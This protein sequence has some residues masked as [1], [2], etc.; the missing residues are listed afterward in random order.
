MTPAIT[1]QM[2]QALDAEHG[3]PVK[4][5]DEKTSQVYYVISAVYFLPSTLYFRLRRKSG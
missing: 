3:Q 5:V 4:I 2:R 1:D